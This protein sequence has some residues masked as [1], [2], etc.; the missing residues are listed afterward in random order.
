MTRARP[1]L[2]LAQVT[3]LDSATTTLNS[4]VP[5]SLASY[6]GLAGS[7]ATVYNAMPTPKSGEVQNVLRTVT[8]LE[9]QVVNTP[10]TVRTQVG[11]GSAPAAGRGPGFRLAPRQASVWLRLR[12]PSCTTCG[13]CARQHQVTNI[14][15]SFG[16]GVDKLQTSV[17]DKIN[18]FKADN[19]DNVE[20]IDNRRYL[21][22]CLTY[23]SETATL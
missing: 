4:R 5:A 17:I 15:N 11:M 1:S 10:T 19:Q 6:I 9:N 18:K 7:V 20:S 14:Q 13:F 21:T 3:N 8:T 2:D 16:S 22:V 23:A 12:A